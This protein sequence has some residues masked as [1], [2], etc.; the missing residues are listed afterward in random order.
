MKEET[1]KSETQTENLHEQK[2]KEETI[3]S[4]RQSSFQDVQV[5]YL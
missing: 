5:E 2:I 4:L 1:P 3:T